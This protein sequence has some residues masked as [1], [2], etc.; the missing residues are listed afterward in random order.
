MDS[1]WKLLAKMG[2]GP[3]APESS[4]PADYPR[5]VEI[6]DDQALLL[7]PGCSTREM[8]RG[9]RPAGPRRCSSR[10]RRPRPSCSPGWRRSTRT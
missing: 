4:N 8:R 2:I 6:V 9:R 5:A 10:C 1:F 7:Q 3:V